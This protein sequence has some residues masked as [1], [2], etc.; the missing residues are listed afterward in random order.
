MSIIAVYGSLRPGLTQHAAYLAGCQ[1]HGTK[2]LKGF[3]LYDA[4]G[5]PCAVPALGEAITVDLFSVTPF[6]LERIDEL[7]GA[8]AIYRRIFT[9]AGFYLYVTTAGRVAHM[10]R[11]A[12]GDWKRRDVSTETGGPTGIV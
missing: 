7:K 4:G 12:S 10:P 3:A 9:A 2:R 5:F 6:H 11:V 1:H 8:P